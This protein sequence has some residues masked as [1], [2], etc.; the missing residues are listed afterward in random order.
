LI[1]SVRG[2]NADRD[3]IPVFAPE[4][5]I[6]HQADG[7]SAVD[8]AL[9]IHGDC[10]GFAAVARRRLYRERIPC[11]SADSSRDG[12]DLSCLPKSWPSR[13]DSRTARRSDGTQY[14]AAP[15][16]HNRGGSSAECIH[17]H[18]RGPAFR[19]MLDRRRRNDVR[20]EKAM[21][22][23]WPA[24]DRIDRIDTSGFGW[25]ES[26]AQ[27]FPFCFPFYNPS[28][29]QRVH[30]A[31]PNHRALQSQAVRIC[32]LTVRWLQRR[33]LATKVH[34]LTRGPTP[35]C[36]AATKRTTADPSVASISKTVEK[37][38]ELTW[39]NQA[40]IMIRLSASTQIQLL[41]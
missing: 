41:I 17:D 40:P 26:G 39:S 36:G 7:N 14:A 6:R 31:P 27:N 22:R 35:T 9:L 19:W 8:N 32:G 15:S 37:S 12:L 24:A 38:T 10:D 4:S 5:D 33:Y 30:C 25:R 28:D 29:L 21:L 20:E 34:N 3:V 18:L 13:R 11:D 16:C 23:P 1:L 2:A